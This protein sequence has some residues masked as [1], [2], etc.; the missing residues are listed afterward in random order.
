MAESDQKADIEQME[1]GTADETADQAGGGT[2]ADR[3]ELAAKFAE[4]QAKADEN[5]NQFLRARA[6]LENYR[7]R[8]ERELEQTRKY[9]SE[10]LIGELL[11]IKDSLEMGIAAARESSDIA[12][13][14]EGSEL[15]LKMLTQALERF[16]LTELNPLGEK[17]DPEK[18]EAMAAQPSAE[19]DA[20]TVLHVVQKGYQLHDRV[21]RPAMVIVSKPADGQKPGQIDEQA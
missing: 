11:P 8:A 19:H 4:A 12:K 21:V 15:T 1:Q 10:K 6:E 9:G 7:R 20:N 14:I 18:H 17:F 2:R 3:E 5:W 16:N 13:L